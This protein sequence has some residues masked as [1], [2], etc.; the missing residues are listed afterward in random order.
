MNKFLTIAKAWGIAVFHTEEEKKLADERME[1]CNTCPSLQEV[2]VKSMT[3][4]LIN[5]YFLCGS[6]G[7]PM[8]GKMFTPIDAPTE[9]KCPQKKW[10]DQQ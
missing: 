5:N 7:C 4:G 3:G 10:K 2:D 1:V 6:C 9:Q 8:Q